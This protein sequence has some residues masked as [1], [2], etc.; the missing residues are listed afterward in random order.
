LWLRHFTYEYEKPG[1]IRRAL[2][3]PLFIITKEMKDFLQ[4]LLKINERTIK[5]C[6]YTARF[7]LIRGI[8]GQFHCLSPAYHATVISAKAASR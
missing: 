3:V 4:R 7:R 2:F 5:S 6:R 1:G 8:S